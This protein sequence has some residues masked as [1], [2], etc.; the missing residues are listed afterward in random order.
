MENIE[1]IRQLTEKLSENEADLATFFD[2]IPVLF[3]IGSK[4]GYLIKV[5]PE[6]TKYLGWSLEEIT[7]QSWLN[8][9]HPDDVQP[10]VKAAEILEKEALNGFV[11]RYRSK[12]GEYKPLKWY[13]SPWINGKNYG[14][15]LQES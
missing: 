8:F 4:K 15:V 10:T 7:N 12:S 13:I 11:N 6:W 5:N 3:V 2:K 1:K 9:V 14:I